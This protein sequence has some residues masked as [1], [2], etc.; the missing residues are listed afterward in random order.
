LSR[1]PKLTGAVGPN[2]EEEEFLTITH[3]INACPWFL[4]SK[5]RIK[6]F[7]FVAG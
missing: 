1:R 7:G 3:F 2:E 4:I 6:G 5:L